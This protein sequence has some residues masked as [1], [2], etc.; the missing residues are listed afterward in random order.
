MLKD[1]EVAQVGEMVSG[2]MVSGM[3]SGREEMVEEMVSGGSLTPPFWSRKK[4][5]DTS[6]SPTSFSVPGIGSLP[7]LL[8][9]S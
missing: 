1:G 2:E 5:P 3:V 6:F 9:G 7:A 8:R 4:I